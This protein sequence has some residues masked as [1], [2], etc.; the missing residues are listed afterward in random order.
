MDARELILLLPAIPLAAALASALPLSPRAL[1][2]LAPAAGLAILAAG[3]PAARAAL[4]AGP[5][6][7]GPFYLDA[8]SAYMVAIVSL[9]SFAAA[10]FSSGYMARE[11]AE[12]AFDGGRLRWYYFWFFTFITTMFLVLLAGNLGFLWVA[13]EGTTLAT[14]LLVGFYHTRAAV[15]AAWKYVIVC[16]VGIAIALLGTILLYYAALPVAGSPGRALDWPSL[17]G[18]ARSLDPGLVRLAFLLVLVGY[19]TKA[20]LAPMHTWLPDAHSQAPTPVSGLLSGVLISSALYAILRFY[21]VAAATLGPG[22]PSALLLGFGLL[23]IA[24]AAPFVV[25]QRD[26]KRLLAYSSVEHMGVVAAGLGLGGSGGPGAALAAW[27]AVFHLLVHALAKAPLFFAAGNLAHAYGTRRTDRIQGAVRLL[28]LSGTALLL[29][30]FAITG[31]PPFALF[32]SEFAI[33]SG[34]FRQGALGASILFLVLLAVIFGGMIHYAVRMTLGASPRNGR[35][36]GDGDGR[37]NGAP[38]GWDDPAET[39]VGGLGGL[40]VWLPLALVLALGL[41]VPGPVDAAVR[42]AAAIV[43]GGL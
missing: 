13:L 6:Q 11:H 20:G 33:V 39:G 31:S 4:A 36:N 12:G 30:A 37:G 5:L 22:Y 17:V 21:A 43:R 14:A 18:M 23:S 19:G 8:L 3:L 32:A 9:V 7:A 15:E 25:V 41:A 1:G 35:G 28:P 34:G 38:A 42:Q 26:C 40:A 24:V 27:G 10:L 16:T 2:R 29:G